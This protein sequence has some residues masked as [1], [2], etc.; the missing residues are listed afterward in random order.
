MLYQIEPENP[1]QDER[2]GCHQRIP[3]WMCND[4]ASFFWVWG[5]STQIT[6]KTGLNL[7]YL[8]IQCDG[9]IISK[10]WPI[11]MKSHRDWTFRSSTR[12]QSLFSLHDIYLNR[13]D[14][15]QRFQ[16]NCFRGSRGRRVE[17]FPFVNLLSSLAEQCMDDLC[18]LLI[19]SSWL[20]RNKRTKSGIVLTV[21]EWR[22]RKASR[23]KIAT[24]YP[25]RPKIFGFV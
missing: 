14:F 11:T 5:R 19:L 20:V 21:R 22:K 12:D 17:C 10:R 4:D 9:S 6:V 13:V 15:D 18:S 8:F 25:G 2:N 16:S 24:G 3:E 7:P 23:K 1:V